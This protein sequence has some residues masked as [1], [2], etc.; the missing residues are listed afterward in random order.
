[1]LSDRAFLLISS[2]LFPHRFHFLEK[3]ERRNEVKSYLYFKILFLYGVMETNLLL[4]NQEITIT[5]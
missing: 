4:V 5:E 1:M 2:Q 3:E